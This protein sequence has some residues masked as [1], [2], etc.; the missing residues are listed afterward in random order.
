VFYGDVVTYYVLIS[1]VA[2]YGNFID[3]QLCNVTRSILNTVYYI[4]FSL[5]G[6]TLVQVCKVEGE[7]QH[8]PVAYIF[9]LFRTHL[10]ESLLY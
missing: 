7:R 1:Y 3:V 10:L 2:I 5:L 9:Q 6:S 4:F 8:D